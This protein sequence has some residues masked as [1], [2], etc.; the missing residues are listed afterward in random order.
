MAAMATAQNVV[1]LGTTTVPP[2]Q[3]VAAP[4]DPTLTQL[5]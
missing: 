2:L 5:S 3:P 1:Q 4:P